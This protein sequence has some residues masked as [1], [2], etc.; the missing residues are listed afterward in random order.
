MP[1][2]YGA[3]EHRHPC[4]PYLSAHEHLSV[5]GGSQKAP[6]IT[7]AFEGPVQGA[8]QEIAKI[9]QVLGERDR[10]QLASAL[11]AHGQDD[12]IHVDIPRLIGEAR[13]ADQRHGMPLDLE[14]HVRNAWAHGRHFAAARILPGCR[15]DDEIAILGQFAC[16]GISRHFACLTNRR[17]KRSARCHCSLIKM[18]N[19]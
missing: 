9:L 18:A 5:A 12:L 11:V 17:L 4:Y 19:E 7:T 14:R 6:M 1:V 2:H 16:D 13:R 15:L 10:L 8:A 3:K